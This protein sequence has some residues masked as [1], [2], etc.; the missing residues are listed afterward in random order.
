MKLEQAVWYAD[1]YGDFR[2]VGNVKK[3]GKQLLADSE[4]LYYLDG[5]H[6]VNSINMKPGQNTTIVKGCGGSLGAHTFQ[7]GDKMKQQEKEQTKAVEINDDKDSKLGVKI[8]LKICHVRS[9][10]LV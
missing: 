4:N 1:Q 5:A 8:G 7:L 2:S 3:K 6:S 9:S 10:L